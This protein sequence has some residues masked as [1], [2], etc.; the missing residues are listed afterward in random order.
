[1]CNSRAP[2]L[3]LSFNEPEGVVFEP[4]T[5]V[6]VYVYFPRALSLSLHKKKNEPE[7]VVFEPDT[8]A[9]RVLLNPGIVEGMHQIQPA[10]AARAVDVPVPPPVVANDM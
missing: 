2:S 4:D 1:M 3:S 7:G 8:P 10:V 6:Y 5:L 9:V